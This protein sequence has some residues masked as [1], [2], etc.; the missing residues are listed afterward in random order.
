MATLGIE[1]ATKKYNI[2]EDGTEINVK[3][4]DTAG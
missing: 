1:F 2:K 3:V 4:W